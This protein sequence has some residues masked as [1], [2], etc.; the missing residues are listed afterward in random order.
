MQP[1][2]FDSNDNDPVWKV[3]YQTIRKVRLALL[4]VFLMHIGFS[5]RELSAFNLATWVFYFN[6]WSYLLAL[7]HLC[8]F[9]KTEADARVTRRCSD[10]FF[11]ALWTNLLFS[12]LYAVVFYVG[13]TNPNRLDY[14]ISIPTVIIPLFVMLIEA[15]LN[16]VYVTPNDKRFGWFL[17]GIYLV[18]HFFGSLLF[19]TSFYGERL[20]WGKGETWV[21]LLAGVVW[22]AVF[23]QAVAMFLYYKYVSKRDILIDA[24]VY[25]SYAGQMT[26]MTRL[27]DGSF[28]I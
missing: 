20:Q 21:F 9:L 5:Y 24:S 1:S 8:F 7:G 10:L 26:T 27:T 13:S 23:D 18:L 2:N 15:A 25:D 22:G 19:G 11:A 17:V 28:H 4:A 16:R 6:N 14:P 12:F 3:R